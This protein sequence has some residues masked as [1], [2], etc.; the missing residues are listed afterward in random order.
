V[1]TSGAT[2]RAVATP[3]PAAPSP[4]AGPAIACMIAFD[5]DRD[6]NREIYVMGPDGKN[7]VNLTK[8]PAEDWNP[9]WSPDGS[10]IAFISKRGNS[11]GAGIVWIMDADGS[12]V[13]RLPTEG[14]SDSPDWSP[15]GR[16]IVYNAGGEI[17]KIASDG[18]SPSIL[19]TQ[20][21]TMDVQPAW[22]PDGTM[23]AWLTEGASGHDV[24][25]MGADGSKPRQLTDSGRPG[26]VRW[27]SDNRLFIDAWGWKDRQE[28][29][30]NCVFDPD[31][32]N[33]VDAGGK[34]DVQRF[35]PFWTASGDRVSLI[36]MAL[37]GKQSDVYLVS[38]KYSGN[39]LDLT[40][41]PAQD[42][43]ADYPPTCGPSGAKAS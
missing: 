8:D 23:I 41:N 25:V 35:L 16:W 42:L 40:N 39:F 34:N 43:N 4:T 20:N 28:S 10:R 36:D 22:S 2:L 30:H 31:G 15:D 11:E 17:H 1:P 26:V 21:A 32:T 6:T 13:R 3:F 27:T 29:C 7:P 24:W 19:L 37:D 33:I 9:E 12:N 18:N 38:E 14:G 5:S